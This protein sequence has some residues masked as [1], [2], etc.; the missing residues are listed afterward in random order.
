MSARVGS[1]VLQDL[2]VEARHGGKQRGARLPD[3][4]RPQRGVLLAGVDDGGGAVGPRIGEAGAEREGPVEGARV[5]HAVV[6]ADPVPALIHGP[7]SEGGALR[8]QHAFGLRRGAGGVDQEGGI[9][10]GGVGEGAARALGD[11]A[12]DLVGLDRR[13]TPPGRPSEPKIASARDRLGAAVLQKKARFRLGELRRRRQR[14]EAA[15]DRAEEEQRVGA[16]VLQPDE[17]ARAG[18]EPARLEARGDAQDRVLELGK[19]PH[20]CRR[21]RHPHPR[22]R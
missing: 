21:S 3:E 13:C 12:R 18:R 9:V 6:G 11:H 14:H 16:R 10:G 22:R 17:D 5:Q 4:A 19:R 7:A 1:R 20:L 8:V 15:G 2:A